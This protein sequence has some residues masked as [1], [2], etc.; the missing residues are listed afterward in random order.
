M[1]IILFT[2]F[3]L[4]LY[5]LL[6]WLSAKD[7]E[8]TL[9]AYKIMLQSTLVSL[10]ILWPVLFVSLLWVLFVAV[11]LAVSA[12]YFSSQKGLFGHLAKQGVFGGIWLTAPLYVLL[13]LST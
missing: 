1:K 3:C 13:F 8:S 12:I 7:Q 9:Q 4:T 10:C 11:I 6:I 5:I 2:A